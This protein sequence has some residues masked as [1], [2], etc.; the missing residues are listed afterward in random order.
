M[1]AN[2]AGRPLWGI[3]LRYWLTST[4]HRRGPMTVAELSR[5]ASGAGFPVPGRASKTISDALRW[6]VR[7]GRVVRLGRGRYGPGTMPRSTA[8]RIHARAHRREHQVTSP[9]GR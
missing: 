2:P 4:L 7:R 6:E 5:A 8:Q 3:E 1:D 9:I